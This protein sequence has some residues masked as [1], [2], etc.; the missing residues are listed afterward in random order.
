LESSVGHISHSGEVWVFI[1][2]SSDLREHDR[3][4]LARIGTFEVNLLP[5]L[6]G[7]GLTSDNPRSVR[8]LVSTGL[9]NHE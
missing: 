9:N 3:L 5:S 6:I 4:L 8:K 1:L 7:V 2:L